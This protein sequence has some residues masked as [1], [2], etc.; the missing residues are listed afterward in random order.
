MSVIIHGQEEKARLK[1]RDEVR[2][3]HSNLRIPFQEWEYE[4]SDFAAR[5]DFQARVPHDCTHAYTYVQV[6][7]RSTL[8]RC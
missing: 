3:N 1:F 2:P 6:Y 7:I 8:Y 5:H 4:R